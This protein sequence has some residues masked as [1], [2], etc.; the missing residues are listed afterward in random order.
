MLKSDLLLIKYPLFEIIHDKAVPKLK[1]SSGILVSHYFIK[2]VVCFGQRAKAVTSGSVN[3]DVD[4][5][6][7]SNFDTILSERKQFTFNCYAENE[8]EVKQILKDDLLYI[9]NNYLIK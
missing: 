3:D 6:T 8:N 9:I 5:R 7:F 1:N 2:C 4:T